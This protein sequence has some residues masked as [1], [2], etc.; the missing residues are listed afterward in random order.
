MRYFPLMMDT[1]DKKVLVV[2]GGKAATTKI[3][4]LLLSSFTFYCLS[5]D[6]Y[7][8]LRELAAAHPDRIFLKEK[9]VDEDFRFFTYDFFIVATDDEALNATLT[10]R[11]KLASVPV[12]STSDPDNS[13]FNMASVVC[14]GPLTISISA[15]NPT[16]SKYVKR[17]IDGFLS[18]Y[19][20]EKLYEMNRIRKLLVERKSEHISQIMEELWNEEKISKNYVEAWDDP[21]SRNERKPSG[22][23]SDEAGRRDSE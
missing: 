1:K 4:G 21:E 8:G 9:A 23:D 7:E 3:K 18:Q 12:L 13:D 6:F 19:D 2:G 11:A 17:D 10:R 15:N 14:R 20:E 22:E 16:V 5:P